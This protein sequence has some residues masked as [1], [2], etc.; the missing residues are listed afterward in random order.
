VKKLIFVLLFLAIFVVG[1]SAD[2]L[3]YTTEPVAVPSQAKEVTTLQPPVQDVDL[4][5][6]MKSVGFQVLVRVKRLRRTLNWFK[7]E[8]GTKLNQDELTRMSDDEKKW[9][10]QGYIVEYGATRRLV[11]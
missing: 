10:A 8:D 3:D 5:N 11:D 6:F 4:I 7:F 1:V 2:T 9:Y